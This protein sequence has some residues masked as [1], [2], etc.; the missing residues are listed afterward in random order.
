MAYTHYPSGA[1]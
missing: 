1:P